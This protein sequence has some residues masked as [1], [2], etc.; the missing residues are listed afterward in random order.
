MT[1]SGGW[2]HSQETCTKIAATRRE[3]L[4]DPAERSKISEATKARMADPAVRQRI[5]EGMLKASGSA[6]EL[7]A[8]RAVWR[9]TR[10]TVRKR[11]LA[12]LLEPICH[13]G[14]EDDQS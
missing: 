8:L 4:R 13:S 14:R 3:Q 12:E 11:F 1:K 9:A 10:P 5:R 6:D 7:R 2:K